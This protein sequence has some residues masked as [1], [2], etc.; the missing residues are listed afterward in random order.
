MPALP[1]IFKSIISDVD[2]IY[3]I[4]NPALDTETDATLIYGRILRGKYPL[5]LVSMPQRQI[6]FHCF[7]PVVFPFHISFSSYA[8]EKWLGCVSSSSCIFASLEPLIAVVNKNGLETVL[9]RHRDV[10]ICSFLSPLFSSN[11]SKQCFEL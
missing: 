5:H 4:I 8:E 9:T 3:F 2:V 10:N 6:R 7:S 1:Q 11:S